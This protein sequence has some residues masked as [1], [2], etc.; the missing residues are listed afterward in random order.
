M[1]PI[2]HVFWTGKNINGDIKNFLLKFFFSFLGKKIYKSSQRAREAMNAFS[3][4]CID[5]PSKGHLISKHHLIFKYRTSKAQKFFFF[6]NIYLRVTR[7]PFYLRAPSPPHLLAVPGLRPGPAPPR[8]TRR[9]ISAPSKRR[10][11]I[12]LLTSVIRVRRENFSYFFLVFRASR[13]KIS[14]LS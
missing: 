5:V 1:S 6:K 7:V 8:A 13:K 10:I 9:I 12:I 3:K 11:R 14:N 4:I 2:S